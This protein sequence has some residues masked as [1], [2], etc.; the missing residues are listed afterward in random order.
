V[1]RASRTGDVI[2]KIVNTGAVPQPLHVRLAGARSLAS[3]ATKTVLTGDPKTVN[4]FD[5][6][7]PLLPTAAAIPVGESFADEAPAHSFTVIRI[8]AR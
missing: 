1:V 2:F 7:A 8:P 4:G 5:N 6:P 3:V